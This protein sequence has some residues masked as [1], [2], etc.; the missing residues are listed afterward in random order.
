MRLSSAGFELIKHYEG[1]KLEAYL[2]PVG[3]WTIGYGHTRTARADMKIT[4]PE[5]D[6]LLV[7]D[8][9]AFENVVSQFVKVPLE[10]HEF[11]ALVCFAFNVGGAAFRKSTL[12][13]MLNKGQKEAIPAQ[14]MRWVNA[15]GK[16]LKGLENRRR[17]EAGL[18]RGLGAQC[19]G[20]ACHIKPDEPLPAKSLLQSKT[21]IA[22]SV[23]T[24]VGTLT[25]VNEAVQ[26]ARVTIDSTMSLA[27]LFN[28]WVLAAVV[29]LAAG[30]L[31]VWD[32]YQKLQEGV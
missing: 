9:R 3:V 12:L 28:P 16:R 19:F 7:R 21:T 11:D 32:R 22:A 23:G 8:V 30:A 2:C 25:A 15:N 18:W 26:T 27:N 20:E 1:L 31:I 6:A 10:Q 13:K 29:I 5:A 17:A 24:S 14:L 4:E